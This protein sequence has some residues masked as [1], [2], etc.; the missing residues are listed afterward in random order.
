[1]NGLLTLA[2]GGKVRLLTLP[3]PL[4]SVEEA[5]CWFAVARPPI[6]CGRKIRVADGRAGYMVLTDDNEGAGLMASGREEE[7]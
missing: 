3:P 5:R 1:M 6:A 4:L 7:G 2:S